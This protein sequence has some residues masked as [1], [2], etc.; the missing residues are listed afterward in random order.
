MCKYC[1]KN[2]TIKEKFFDITIINSCLVVGN[3]C[4][5][6]CGY[7][8]TRF[9]INY[10]M[11]CRKEAGR[12][13]DIFIQLKDKTNGRKSNRIRLE[14]IIFNSDEIEFEFGKYDNENYETLPFKDFLFYKD[15]FE[16]IKI[17]KQ[18]KEESYDK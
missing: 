16:L 4:S 3:E 7:D 1:E 9:N 5:E 11:F 14:D 2:E 8:R 13:I 6:G 12:V 18:K 10:C 15:D 17:V